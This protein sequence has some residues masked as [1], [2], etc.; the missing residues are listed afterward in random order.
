MPNDQLFSYFM[1]IKSYNFDKMM[2]M[3]MMIMMPVLY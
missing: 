3:M 1:A 2:M